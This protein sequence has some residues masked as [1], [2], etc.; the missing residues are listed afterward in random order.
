[1]THPSSMF[2]TSAQNRRR[3]RCLISIQ[4]NNH[5]MR[6]LPRCV[7]RSLIANKF[8]ESFKLGPHFYRI[9]EQIIRRYAGHVVIQISIWLRHSV[10]NS[11]MCLW[12]QVSVEYVCPETFRSSVPF[13][14]RMLIIS[15]DWRSIALL[16]IFLLYFPLSRVLSFSRYVPSY[17]R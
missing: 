12:P 13:S 6:S 8:G 10:L 4:P 9:S 11:R 5:R 16:L 14:F 3:T 2:L 17:N 15:L 7:P 1:V